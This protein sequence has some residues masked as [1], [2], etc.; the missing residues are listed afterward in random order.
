MGIWHL[1]VMRNHPARLWN[2]RLSAKVVPRVTM[3]SHM[4]RNIFYWIGLKKQGSCSVNFL[5]DAN[6]EIEGPCAKGKTCFASW[7]LVEPRVFR[8]CPAGA[9][10]LGQL[11]GRPR[12]RNHRLPSSALRPPLHVSLGV[13]ARSLLFSRSWVDELWLELCA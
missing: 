7:W 3:I 2:W 12:W 6:M 8:G 10:A 1:F 5:T 4:W 9:G 11:Q 13:R